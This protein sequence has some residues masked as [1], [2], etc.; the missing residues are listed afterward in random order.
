VGQA[1]QEHDVDVVA[2][3]LAAEAIEVGLHLLGGGG[4]RLGHHH[5]V[6]LAHPAHPSRRCGWVPY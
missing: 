5:H 3:Q 1:V 2:A 4:A 6:V